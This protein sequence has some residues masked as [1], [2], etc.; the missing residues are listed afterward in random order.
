MPVVGEGDDL[1]GL[2]GLGDLGVG[3][4]HL[5]AGVVLG[6]EGEHR[7]GALGAFGHVVLFQDAVARAVGW[8][9]AVVADGVEVA[10]EPGLAGGQ[11]ECA[12][13]ADQPGEQLLV[14]FAAH[15]VGVGAQVGGLGQG[16]QSEGGGQAEVVDQRAEV[17][18]PGAAGAL[19][20]QQRRDRLPSGERPGRGVAALADQLGQAQLGHRR[21]Q[22]QQPGVIRGQRGVGGPARQR[23]GLDPGQLR[24]AAPTGLV[25]ARQ[26]GQA[27]GGQDLPH[28]L[29]GDRQALRGQRLGDLADAVLRGAQHQH[30]LAQFPGGLAR[31]PSVRAW[32]RRTGSASPTAAAWPSGAPTR[33]SSRTGRP[34][35][36]RTTRA[37]S[38]RAAPRSGV[39]PSRWAG[40]RTPHPTSTGLPNGHTGTVEL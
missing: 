1:A 18:H 3:V 35:A 31:V 2:F 29:R 20:Q 34:P 10:V 7:A 4:D 12:Q 6:E 39:A 38:R 36:R 19:G 37:R 23:A 9:V 15:P 26:P 14:G 13:G 30:P 8:V 27:L 21:E 32:A 5:G 28:R 22:Q 16:G 33:W 17:V 24:R 40:G 11:P 25:A